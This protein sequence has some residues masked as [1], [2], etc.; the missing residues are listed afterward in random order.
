MV[1]VALSMVWKAAL[2]SS[3]TMQRVGS[4]SVRVRRIL[5]ILLT[6][7]DMPVPY[8]SVHVYWLMLSFSVMAMALVPIRR[9]MFVR[10]IGL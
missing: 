6:P 9:S 7:S 10:R 2:M 1:M 4:S 5:V 8:W 3:E